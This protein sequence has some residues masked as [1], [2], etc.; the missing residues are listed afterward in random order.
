MIVLSS[1]TKLLTAKYLIK[2][3][4]RLRVF[5]NSGIMLTAYLLIAAA[6][7]EKGY[8]VSFYIALISSV[9]H[10]IS[11]SFGGCTTLGFCK[12]FPH[13]AVGYYSSGTGMAGIVG[14][15]GVLLLKKIGFTDNIIFAIASPTVF[16][17]AYSFYWLYKKKSKHPYI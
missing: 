1:V 2:L 13:Y 14:S 15:G 10:G 3:G 5:I 6:T 12:G 17:Y 4:H 9:L 8:E 7:T 16:I 11:S